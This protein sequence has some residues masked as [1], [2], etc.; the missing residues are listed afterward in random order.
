MSTIY[1]IDVG[2]M[3]FVI[4][5]YIV[6]SI[7][8]A[9]PLLQAIHSEAVALLEDYQEAKALAVDRDAHLREA[10]EQAG[11]WSDP[12][13]SHLS[14]PPASVGHQGRSVILLHGLRRCAH[15]SLCE[16]HT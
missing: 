13:V 2:F 8:D 5:H 15:H 9:D 7:H 6:I 4:Y 14:L 1:R 16:K 12:E 3:F 11:L 10:V